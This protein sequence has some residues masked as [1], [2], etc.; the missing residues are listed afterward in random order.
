[1]TKIDH[2]EQIRLNLIANAAALARAPLP[3]PGAQ[4]V[5]DARDAARYRWLRN[6]A[7]DCGNP[8]YAPIV[9]M[10]DWTGKVLRDG[11]NDDGIRS[12]DDLDRDVDAAMRANDSAAEEGNHG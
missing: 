6:E 10:M 9:V 7:R 3:A 4:P 5:D 1:M 2:C 11:T 12:D 8:D